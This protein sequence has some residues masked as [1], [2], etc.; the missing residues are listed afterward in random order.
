VYFIVFVEQYLFHIRKLLYLLVVSHAVI[1][2]SQ[3][4]TAALK[5]IIKHTVQ[6]KTLFSSLHSVLSSHVVG[7]ELEIKSLP[8][9]RI[10][11]Q[12]WN[13]NIKSLRG[14]RS[15]LME[16]LVSEKMFVSHLD[17]LPNVI[18]MFLLHIHEV[19][20]SNLCLETGCPD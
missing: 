8:H 4:V 2:G 18:K 14:P 10:S 15:L 17:F 12:V 20:S 6:Q 1:A 7:P 11:W 19:C 3:Q 13:F 5:F 9:Y 16:P